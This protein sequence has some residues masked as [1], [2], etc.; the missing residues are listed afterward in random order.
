MLLFESVGIG[1]A[2]LIQLLESLGE[3]IVFSSPGELMVY[4]LSG[5]CPASVRSHFFLGGGRTGLMVRA[6]DSGSGCLFP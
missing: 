6:S 5:V 4:P 1:Y 3:Q 2:P